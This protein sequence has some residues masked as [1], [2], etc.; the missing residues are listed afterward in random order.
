MD[1]KGIVIIG[2]GPG[3][4][5]S[6]IRS[7]QLGARVTLI[8]KERIGGTCLH[9]GCIPTKTLL[10]DAKMFHSLKRSNVFQS[11]ILEE[12]NPLRLMMD[13][14]RDVVDELARGLMLLLDSYGVKVKYAQAR[15]LENRRLL[16]SDGS[17]KNEILKADALI[18]ATG[19]RYRIPSDITPDG[20]KIITSDEALEIMSIPDEMVI[21]GGGYIGVEFATL[22]N[23]LGA[24]VTIVEILENILPSIEYELVRNLRRFMERDGIRIFTRSRI[25]EIHEKEDGLRISIKTPD[26]IKELSCEKLLLSTGRIPNLDMDFSRIGLEVSPSGIEVNHRMETAVPQIYAVGDVTGRHFLA[27]TA[28]EEGIVAS[29]NIMGHNSEIKDSLIPICIFTDPE[30]ASIGLTEKEAKERGEIKVGR[31]P[32]RSNPTAVIC[33]EKD[34]LIKV[35]SSKESDEILG[36]HIIGRDASTLISIASSMMRGGGRVKD[37]SKLIQAHPTLPEALREAL[38]DVDKMAIH[39]PKPIHR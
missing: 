6:A 24:R 8:E 16:I 28:M 19:S 17:G 5:V 14:K 35:I 9:R 2:G 38:L 13:R 36:V 20:I 34:G 22:F 1:S 12:F 18:I 31:F 10:H 39:L 4:Y 23:L 21:L 15:L 30:I 26:G 33:G 3:G 29:E 27:H 7:A 37:F 11:L 25:E 32:F